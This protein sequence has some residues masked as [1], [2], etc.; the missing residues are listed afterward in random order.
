M[1]IIKCPECGHQISEKATVCPSCGVEIAGKITKCLGCGEVFFIDMGLCP[2]CY[3][4][5]SGHKAAPAPADEDETVVERPKQE[6]PVKEELAK[7]EP[8]QD[9]NE[10]PRQDEEEVSHPETESHQADDFDDDTDVAIADEDPIDEEEEE[11]ED[12]EPADEHAEDDTEDQ[13]IDTDGEQ[14]EKPVHESDDEESTP[15]GKKNYIPV[16]VSLAITA[17]IA[18]VCFYFYQDTK[19]SRETEAFELAMKSE[20]VHQLNSFLRNFTD[21]SSEH[22][23]AINDKIASITKEEEALSLSLATRDK[24]KLTSYLADYPDSPQRQ[25][26]LAMIDSIDWDE[27]VKTNTKA[28]YDKYIAEHA[29]GQFIQEAKDKVAVKVLVASAEDEAMA[30]SLFRE[31]FLSVNGNDAAR[32]SPTLSGEISSFMGTEKASSGQVVDWMKRQ[33]GDDVSSV[34]WKLNHDYKITKREQGGSKNYDIEFTAKQTIVRKDG[35]SSSENY[36][37]TSGVSGNNK[38]SSMNMTKYVPQA[39]PATST[40]SS[41]TSTTQA[42][43]AAAPQA[44]PATSTQAKPAASAQAKPAT[45]SQAKPAASSQTKPAASSQ[46][47]PAASSQAKPAAKENTSKPS[48]G[49]TN[50]SAKP[51]APVSSKPADKAQTQPKK[52]APKSDKPSTQQGNTKK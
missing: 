21:A 15:S 44:K 16:I 14:L 51:K 38:I 3:R 19:M 24:A 52:E 10:E 37:I 22:K 29:T 13:Y 9:K 12:S 32:L 25:K 50:T 31:F 33:H 47:K 2:H 18:A 36:R 4:P 46:A 7:E 26:I 20:D 6:E 34:I 39:A 35:R 11:K 28:A 48:T 1:A 41:S 40:S 42:K 17:L 43:P 5:Y 45:S 8:R 49:T 23:A 30:K 27:A